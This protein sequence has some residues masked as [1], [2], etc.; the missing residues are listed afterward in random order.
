MNTFKLS[1]KKVY[2][3][4]RS[5]IENLH[6]EKIDSILNKYD[7]LNNKKEQLQ[8]NNEKLK[9]LHKKNIKDSNKIS[10]ISEEN[11]QLEKEIHDIENNVEL[12][13]YLFN[14]F[15]FIKKFDEN[16]DTSNVSN[17]SN[18]SN[19]SNASNTSNVSNVTKTLN[20]STEMER[21]TG[22]GEN[23]NGETRNILNFVNMK[24]KTNKGEEYR[25]YYEK[26]ILNRCI[27]NRDTSCRCCRQN[28]FEIDTKNG[29]QICKNCGNCE[30]YI[31]TTS[32]YVN[33][34]DTKQ[35]ETICQPFSYQRK[36]HFKEWLNQLQ[37][38]EVTEIPETVINLLLLEIKKERITNVKDITSER[39][40]KYLKKLKLNK[41]YEH[42]PNII[43]NITNSPPL[44]I[45][46]EFEEVL[47]DL[48]NKIQDPFKKYCPSTRKNFLSYSYTIHK[49]CQLLGKDEYLIYFPLL[50]SREK[51]FEQEKI[52]KNICKELNWK[53]I[54]SI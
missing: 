3:D 52:W 48:F 8:L 54:P 30:T 37:A 21:E 23:E 43:S 16:N 2:N 25:K 34:N 36:N 12:S 15:E 4:T 11:Y 28:N 14:A 13:D 7:K 38:K 51:L 29:L 42:I 22:N 53:F 1:N 24:G 39:I 31:D 5:T 27:T 45:S 18:G 20:D 32:N 44:S 17:T 6:N 49:F 10:K 33:F 19:T 9:I 40:K 46:E 47:L 41:Y 50:K 26:C 35:Y